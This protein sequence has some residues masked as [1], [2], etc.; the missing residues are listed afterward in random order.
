MNM[1]SAKYCA[2]VWHGASAATTT[3]EWSY[4]LD[5]QW[6]WV[7]KIKYGMQK[8]HVKSFEYICW[9]YSH[10]SHQW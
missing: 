6:F 3:R 1:H 7:H 4:S 5:K 9:I 2:H 8:W 10:T